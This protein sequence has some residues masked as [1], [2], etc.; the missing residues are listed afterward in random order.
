MFLQLVLK[1]LKQKGKGVGKPTLPEL[2]IFQN[3][4]WNSQ[5]LTFDIKTMEDKA[6]KKEISLGFET[7]SELPVNSKEV[8]PHKWDYF[9]T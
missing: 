3:L 7:I 9:D 1:E 8:V 2:K 6:P 4:V 5:T